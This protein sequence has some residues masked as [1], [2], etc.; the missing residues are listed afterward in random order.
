M[1]V[2][3]RE[4]RTGTAGNPVAPELFEIMAAPDT[5]GKDELWFHDSQIEGAGYSVPV[6]NGFP[7]FVANAPPVRKSIEVTIPVTDRPHKSVFSCPEVPAS[8]PADFGE[9]KYKWH[10]LNTQE[11][12]FLLDAG[13]GFEN[14]RTFEQMGYR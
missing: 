1:P 6:R 12:G 4:Q 8:V 11:R 7:D 2:P 3:V 9:N 13:C 5:D 14:R 10:S